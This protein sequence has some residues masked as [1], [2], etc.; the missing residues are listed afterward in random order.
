MVNQFSWMGKLWLKLAEM[1][2]AAAKIRNS[3]FAFFFSFFFPGELHGFKL[4]K[5]R[6]QFQLYRSAQFQSWPMTHHHTLS[7]PQ[8]NHFVFILHF[9]KNETK[10][11]WKW[12]VNFVYFWRYYVI[13]SNRFNAHWKENRN[14][15]GMGE[16]R[17]R[18]RIMMKCLELLSLNFP[19]Q[20]CIMPWCFAIM[21]KSDESKNTSSFA[22]Y[23]ASLPF[24]NPLCT[25]VNPSCIFHV[26]VFATRENL[27]NPLIQYCCLCIVSWAGIWNNVRY[28]E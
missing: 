2:K 10:F 27:I 4:R 17:E 12:K 28:I 19:A 22:W 11:R 1:N 20:E 14:A 23:L 8:I 13:R 16:K 5:K 18:E 21:R 9:T 7:M 6:V 15:D 24:D 26:E 3:L 25:P